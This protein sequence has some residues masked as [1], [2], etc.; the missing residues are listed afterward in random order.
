MWIA[1]STVAMGGRKCY[2][3]IEGKVEM[4][5]RSTQVRRLYH[6]QKYRYGRAIIQVQLASVMG[7]QAGE[8][9]V[10]WQRHEVKTTLTAL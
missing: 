5:P 7:R 1:G 10:R 8:A 4:R 9:D 6:A 2:G 3:W